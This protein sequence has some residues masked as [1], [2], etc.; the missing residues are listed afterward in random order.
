MPYF[1]V[2]E[3]SKTFVDTPHFIQNNGMPIKVSI[4]DRCVV[5]AGPSSQSDFVYR[6]DVTFPFTANSLC[7][8]S[9][10]FVSS[11]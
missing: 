4:F 6:V 3:V 8:D 10:H 2:C 11:H 5:A 1:F 7:S 9:V